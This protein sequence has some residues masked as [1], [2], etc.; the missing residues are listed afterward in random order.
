MSYKEYQPTIYVAN[1]KNIF[2][3]N[4]SDLYPSSVPNVS[5][6]TEV[7]GSRP[8]FL[9]PYTASIVLEGTF[10]HAIYDGLYYKLLK[11]RVQ[12]VTKDIYEYQME[13]DVMLNVLASKCEIKGTLIRTNDPEILE[14]CLQTTTPILE[15]PSSH[16]IGSF[17]IKQ[18]DWKQDLEVLFP[19]DP[20]L[21]VD[22]AF[23][24]W[25]RFINRV[26][27]N[28][29]VLSL[30]EGIKWDTEKAA[31][32]QKHSINPLFVVDVLQKSISVSW[33][34]E[35]ISMIS[36]FLSNLDDVEIRVQSTIAGSKLQGKKC[37]THKTDAIGDVVDETSK[38]EKI[39]LSTLTDVVMIDHNLQP[40]SE[41]NPNSY[42]KRFD[43]SK[44]SDDFIISELEDKDLFWYCKL[45][46][47]PHLPLKPKGQPIEELQSYLPIDIGA[48]RQR[49]KN[50]EESEYTGFP[51]QLITLKEGVG[52]KSSKKGW[53][54][55]INRIDFALVDGWRGWYYDE[56]SKDQYKIFDQRTYFDDGRD[57][58]SLYFFRNLDRRSIPPVGF[59]IYQLNQPHEKWDDY[60]YLDEQPLKKLTYRSGLNTNLLNTNEENHWW[61]AAN[62]QMR[63]INGIEELSLLTLQLDFLNW[64]CFAPSIAEGF[65][66]KWLDDNY[67]GY[68]TFHQQQGHSTGYYYYPAEFLNWDLAGNG[69]VFQN[70]IRDNTKSLGHIYSRENLINTVSLYDEIDLKYETYYKDTS[71]NPIIKEVVINQNDIFCSD[72]DW[73]FKETPF[74]INELPF[75]I[76]QTVLEKLGSIIPKSAAG[77]A[78]AGAVGVIGKQ[79][80]KSWRVDRDFRA[81]NR[82]IN[83]GRFKPSKFGE[84]KD[85][86]KIT[87]RYIRGKT[88]V[89]GRALHTTKKA[90]KIGKGSLYAARQGAK[91]LWSGVKIAKLKP[92]ISV[93][94]HTFTGARAIAAAKSLGISLA[95]EAAIWGIEAAIS[96]NAPDNQNRQKNSIYTLGDFFGGD[97]IDTDLWDG[98]LV[99]YIHKGEVKYGIYRKYTQNLELSKTD[100]QILESV[101]GTTTR[102]TTFHHIQY[103]GTINLKNEELLPEEVQADLLAKAYGAARETGSDK[104][105]H[106]TKEE[107][108]DINNHQFMLFDLVNTNWI[109]C[110]RAGKIHLICKDNAASFKTIQG[111]THTVTFRKTETPSIYK[112]INQKSTLNV[113]TQQFPL[114]TKF[115]FTDD[116]SFRLYVAPITY[117]YENPKD[118]S[119]LSEVQKKELEYKRQIQ[120]NS[121]LDYYHLTISAPYDH[122]NTWVQVFKRRGTALAKV[123][124]ADYEL[125]KNQ[126]QQLQDSRWIEQQKQ[127]NYLTDV[128]TNTA[129]RFEDLNTEW[130]NQV[131]SIVERGVAGAAIGGI[132]KGAP[133]IITGAA[134]GAISAGVSAGRF[135]LRDYNILNTR[136]KEDEIKIYRD[137][138]LAEYERRQNYEHKFRENTIRLNSMLNTYI[139][140]TTSDDDIQRIFNRGNNWDDINILCLIPTQEQEKEII[141][142]YE[143]FGCMCTSNWYLNKPLLLKS[144]MEPGVFHFSNLTSDGL[145][146][147]L[148]T[149]PWINEVL[150]N[151]L[152][153]GVRF[154]DHIY[155]ALQEE[156]WAIVIPKGVDI[157]FNIDQI[158]DWSKEVWDTYKLK[159]PK[160]EILEILKKTKNFGLTDEEYEKNKDKLEGKDGEELLQNIDQILGHRKQG[161]VFVI[162]THTQEQVETSLIHSLKAKVKELESQL[163]TKNT[164]ISTCQDD[165]TKAKAVIESLGQTSHDRKIDLKN[166][167]KTIEKQKQQIEDLEK[168]KADYEEQLKIC[169]QNL[170]QI[171]QAKDTCDLTNANE[172]KKLKGEIS[173]LKSQLQDKQIELDAQKAGLSASVL[174]AETLSK[175]YKKLEEEKTQLQ[176]LVNLYK[177]EADKFK[178]EVQSKIQEKEHIEDQKADI[179]RQLKE[180][181]DSKKQDEDKI[182]D[183]E[184]RLAVPPSHPDINVCELFQK[185]FKSSDYHIDIKERDNGFSAFTDLAFYLA[186]L[187]RRM[188][189]A[190]VDF[191]LSHY[192]QMKPIF[193][194]LYELEQIPIIDKSQSILKMGG[195]N[196]FVEWLEKGGSKNGEVDRVISATNDLKTKF[197]NLPNVHSV[198]AILDELN[199]ATYTAKTA[200]EEEIKTDTDLDFFFKHIYPGQQLNELYSKLFGVDP[201]LAITRKQFLNRGCVPGEDP[202]RWVDEF[203]KS[204]HINVPISSVRPDRLPPTTTT[205]RMQDNN[206]WVLDEN[207]VHPYFFPRGRGDDVFVFSP[208]GK[209]TLRTMYN[210]FSVFAKNEVSNYPYVRNNKKWSWETF[211]IYGFSA[212]WINTESDAPE[213]YFYNSTWGQSLYVRNSQ[214]KIFKFVHNNRTQ[215]WKN[216]D[217]IIVPDALKEAIKNKQPFWKYIYVRNWNDFRGSCAS[218]RTNFWDNYWGY[219]D[220]P[221]TIDL[222]KVFG[223][224][225]DD[226]Y[227]LL[228]ILDVAKWWLDTDERTC[229]GITN[230]YD[231]IPAIEFYYRLAPTDDATYADLTNN[232]YDRLNRNNIITDEF[233]HPFSVINYVL[234]HIKNPQAPLRSVFDFGKCWKNLDQMCAWADAIKSRSN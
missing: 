78:A 54:W 161:A 182:K 99:V 2:W 3:N 85:A 135:L 168:E 90:Y 151:I 106:I 174:R 166:I 7:Q 42:F 139:Q 141:Q 177:A 58:G 121:F 76:T 165:L 208:D 14:D 67:W 73:D 229:K 200:L 123:N 71:N 87:S 221:L 181:L 228:G 84:L 89:I 10:N 147:K 172:I 148:A 15:N 157:D 31:R 41:K 176:N 25:I 173:K 207:F 6:Y 183:L 24:S 88:S 195:Y 116:S 68:Q 153:N 64:M 184:T 150:R 146:G 194:K 1:F 22:V 224:K 202:L 227:R 16:L 134:V 69:E 20:L 47:K 167:Q 32:S 108:H 40:I 137:N 36:D 122:L 230:K 38:I 185:L 35:I 211:Y 30:Q 128:K 143:E 233:L 198:L 175:Q 105:I 118:Y 11:I 218:G 27:A 98:S 226:A 162:P 72:L 129:R 212:S 17:D 53:L 216:K 66:Y 210:V 55:Y 65:G 114:N 220:Q 107:L 83:L 126:R 170:G 21:D 180:A 164:E 225:A 133:G 94:R 204:A 34:N 91:A 13:Y 231:G 74:A 8:V 214:T 29:Y 156:E 113:F 49:L 18:F 111:N 60:E 196:K 223:K 217:K 102:E 160:S 193:T 192:E 117:D 213:R 187:T 163:E 26:K 222:V 39:D 140:P 23:T 138:S 119:N 96:A 4:N 234:W 110:I 109:A 80:L 62:Y 186:E 56:V 197:T 232:F 124:P 125:I 81:I 77:V 219:T 205:L 50:Y 104:C 103:L 100:A 92:V 44:L 101:D 132:K 120:D 131:S 9:N 149:D 171:Q 189:S 136:L 79:I 130:W 201:Q 45:S 51:P 144:G 159:R 169:E 70:P 48:Y 152:N 52:Q 12:D 46:R 59:L 97:P 203:V 93:L 63:S 19:E 37:F 179:Q 155:E 82:A 142:I 61:G 43:K 199:F 5:L 33:K 191:H 75:E 215:H 28:P 178:K 145:K 158:T 112:K 154:V 209:V 188:R 115:T 127:F 95:I 206:E 57:Y 86:I 190:S